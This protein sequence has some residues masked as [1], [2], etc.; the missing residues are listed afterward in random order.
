M[1]RISNWLLI[2][3]IASR[4]HRTL[5]WPIKMFSYNLELLFLKMRREEKSQV[6]LVEEHKI[7]PDE[8]EIIFFRERWAQYS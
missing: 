6:T 5:P 4:F 2:I 3:L 7:R 8:N 1:S